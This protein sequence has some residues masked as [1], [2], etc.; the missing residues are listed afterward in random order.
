MILSCNQADTFMHRLLQYKL[1]IDLSNFNKFTV[2][3]RFVRKKRQM[4]ILFQI[5]NKHEFFSF[6][7]VKAIQFVE[8][9]I[10]QFFDKHF[11]IRIS[12]PLTIELRF[13]FQN[14]K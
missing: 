10:L 5:V 14:K 3:I 4:N 9:K 2:F 11:S 13:F 7:T 1:P 6:K 8:K 12:S